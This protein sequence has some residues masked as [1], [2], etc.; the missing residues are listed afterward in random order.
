MRMDKLSWGFPQTLQDAQAFRRNG[1]T[2]H[3]ASRTWTD[4]A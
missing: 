4:Q 1:L 2:G 3:M